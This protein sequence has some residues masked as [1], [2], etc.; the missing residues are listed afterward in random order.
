[1]SDDLQPLAA[2]GAL[3]HEIRTAAYYK[4]LAAGRPEGR[5]LEFWCAAEQEFAGARQIAS[6]PSSDGR[7]ASHHELAVRPQALPAPA[8]RA[9]ARSNPPA[10]RSAAR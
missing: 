9:A 7:P 1:M 10:S 6:P 2:T 3:G 5:H 8:K 4:W